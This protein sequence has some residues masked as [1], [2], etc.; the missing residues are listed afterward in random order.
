LFCWLLFAIYV[1]LLT[2]TVRKPVSIFLLVLMLFNVLGYYGVFVGMRYKNTYDLVQRLDAGD[3]NS[4]ETV[5]IR[6]PMSIPYF[7]GSEEYVRVDGE[8]AYEGEVYRLVKQRYANDTLYAVC[9]KDHAG[10]QIDRALTDYV[11]TFSDKSAD[12]HSSGKAIS[13]QLQDYI[14]QNFSIAQSTP[15]WTRC[16]NPLNALPEFTPSYYA[17]IIHPPERG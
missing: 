4:Q 17:S 7:T 5:T 9:I 1:S 11:K 14:V 6:V 16:V 13:I 15:G 8:F 2:R 10:K 12:A 3:Y